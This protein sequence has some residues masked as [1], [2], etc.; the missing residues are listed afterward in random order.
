MDTEIATDSEFYGNGT[1]HKNSQ[2]DEYSIL[3][4]DAYNA[5]NADSEE[6]YVKTISPPPFTPNHS[7]TPALPVDAQSI[8]LDIDG[9]IQCGQYNNIATNVDDIL[10]HLPKDEY[11]RKIIELFHSNEEQIS[12]YRAKLADKARACENPPLGLLKERRK[13]VKGSVLTK[14]ANDCFMLQQFLCGN[15]SDVKHLFKTT[16]SCEENPLSQA[17]TPLNDPN[18][19]SLLKKSLA[20]VQAEMH[21]LKADSRQMRDILTN[22]TGE[23]K[24]EIVN[25]RKELDSC[26]LILNKKLRK[27]S[28]SSLSL[29]QCIPELSDKVKKLELSRNSIKTNVDMLDEIVKDNSRN[30][31]EIFDLEAQKKNDTKL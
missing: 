2:N 7:L 15:M 8:P 3:D 18:D 25:I 9:N 17:Q 24:Q 4:L 27:N 22:L 11:I 21:V 23:V 1:Q 13:S 10:Y 16:S 31:S 14:Y 6:T 26:T 28:D 19:I 5:Q 12:I 20:D 30:I 29:S